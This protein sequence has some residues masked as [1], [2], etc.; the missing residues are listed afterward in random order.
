M[1]LCHTEIIFLSSRSLNIR[2]NVDGLARALA[3]LLTAAENS[4]PEIQDDWRNTGST[5]Y[6]DINFIST[7]LAANSLNF[8]VIDG[9]LALPQ[10]FLEFRQMF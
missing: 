3:F 9:T 10:R 2:D 8:D 6:K 5:G 1:T 7:P 4:V